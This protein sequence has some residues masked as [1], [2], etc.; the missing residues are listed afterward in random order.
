MALLPMPS[1][2]ERARDVLA[3]IGERARLGERPTEIELLDASLVAYQLD[4][5]DVAPLIAWAAM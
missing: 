3:P 4:A 1:D 2:W 5:D